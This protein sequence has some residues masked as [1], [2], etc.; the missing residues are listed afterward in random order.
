MTDGEPSRGKAELHQAQVERDSRLERA[1]LSVE[2]EGTSG[3]DMAKKIRAMKTPPPK[4]VQ[5]KK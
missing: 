5:T 4:D 3:E 2:H 1:A